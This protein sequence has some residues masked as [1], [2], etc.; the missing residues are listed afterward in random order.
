LGKDTVDEIRK[1]THG[2]LAI[3]VHVAKSKESDQAVKLRSILEEWTATYNSLP[4]ARDT[5]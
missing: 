4:E 2:A 3:G 5:R 1:S